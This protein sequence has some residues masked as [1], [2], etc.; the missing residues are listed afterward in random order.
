MIRE[1]KRKHGV[2]HRN[3]KNSVSDLNLA[4]KTPKE[5]LRIQPDIYLGTYQYFDQYFRRDIRQPH[6]VSSILQ[7]KNLPFLDSVDPDVHNL[8][9]GSEQTSENTHRRF[10][11]YRHETSI[12]GLLPPNNPYVACDMKRPSSGK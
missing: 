7:N 2:S 12:G 9:F 1:A 3:Y 11:K 10:G 5:N 6:D 8:T 4:S